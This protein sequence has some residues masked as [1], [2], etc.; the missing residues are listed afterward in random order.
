ML[1]D[2]CFRPVQDDL[3]D[4]DRL[5]FHSDLAAV[6]A[7]RC[8]PSH[9]RFPDS[10]AIRNHCLVFPRTTSRIEHADGRRF[11]GD[12]A[13]ISLY[14]AGQEYRRSMVSPEGDHSDY[15]VIHPSVLR[16]A[17]AARDARRGEADDR[18]LFGQTHT[19]CTAP[20]YAR[21]RQLF[22]A[23]SA[24]AVD[25]LEVEG[26]V[27]DL[28][29]AV[30]DGVTARG[31]TGA[32]LDHRHRQIADATRA[33]LA[34]GY[35]APWTL[36]DIAT[37]IG[38][39]PYHLCRVFRAQTGQSLHQYRNQIRVRAALN[40]IDDGMDLTTVAFDVGYS[41]HSHFT[42]AFRHAF[43]CPPRALRAV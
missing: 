39:S 43:G 40:R 18:D 23:A 10:G 7:W 29:A 14:S 19:H 34:R 4:V 22:R 6:G 1:S 12:Q 25:T 37:R 8:A 24:G 42:A 38:V 31:T 26:R 27:L 30:L 41:S 17:V 20:L 35:A 9:P 16:E 13:T 21:Q 28:L 11:V 3:R 32:A 2:S 33:L 36:R 5:V 15:F